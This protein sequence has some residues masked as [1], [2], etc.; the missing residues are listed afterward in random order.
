MLVRCHFPRRP[1]EFQRSVCMED[2]PRPPSVRA[3][4]IV[5][6]QVLR[7]PVAGMTCEACASSVKLALAKV[8]GVASVE[9]SFG[10]RQAALTFDGAPVE[11]ARLVEALAG[12]GYSIPLAEGAGTGSLREAVAFAEQAERAEQ[13]STRRELVVALVFG[14]PAIAAEFSAADPRIALFLTLVVVGWAGA[15]VLVAGARAAAR[16]AP[17]MNTLVALG[18]V[19]AV[20]A[21]AL[22][23]FGPAEFHAAAHHAH[24]A[25]LILIF[26]LLGRW[27][28]TRA[29]RRAGDA[30]QAL[31]NLTPQT[32]R[33]LRRG[34]EVELPAAEARIGALALVR[35]GERIPVDGTVFGGASEVDE[36]ALTGE[37]RARDVAVG[38]R[39]RA[40]TLNG[41]GALQISIERV[42]E[43]TAV[44]RIAH[45][46]QAA[47]GSRVPIQLLVDR[48]SARFVPLVLAA[49]GAAFV[50]G[51]YGD[52][53][54]IRAASRA[55]AV[56]VVACPCA[57]GLATPAAIVAATG[58]AARQ[59][60]LVREA[61]V[62]ERMA[63]VDTLVLDKTGT[64][65]SGRPRLVGVHALAAAR[66]AALGDDEL[67]K[68]AAAVEVSSEQPLGRALVEAADLRGL[69]YARAV[70]FR[71]EPGRGVRGRVGA[72]ELWLGSPHAAGARLATLDRADPAIEPLCEQ[73]AGRGASPVVLLCDDR[74]YAVFELR[75]IPRPEAAA[76][77]RA[78]EA[79]GIAIHVCS[80]DHH[81]AVAFVAAELG[82]SH[83]RAGS[84]P[85]Q[86][87]AYVR[88]LRAAGRR[89]LMVGDGVN[90]A[91]A[92]ASADVGL[93]IG[94]G[95]DVALETADAVLL[96]P[97]LTRLPRLLEL[98]R[99]MRST[100]RANLAWA[101]A[102]NAITLP[103]AAGALTPWTTWSPSPGL[104]AAG[105]AGSSLLVVLNSLRLLRVS[106][107]V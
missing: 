20:V 3:P 60:V 31:V 34:V 56:L 30:L 7:V 12:S 107:R 104:A 69:K 26:V 74:A 105:M 102:Y 86:K 41:S 101:F 80:G 61:A 40:G 100:I 87:S 46:V 77:L 63:L 90:D 94:G 84:T 81:G 5:A 8:P 48:I 17:D 6:Q 73:V 14:I 62:I 44:A 36:S 58:A 82:L 29:R 10:A 54:S 53:D 95:A 13:R 55:I 71:A 1:P 49:A 59:G 78:L 33:V 11:R 76:A 66:A 47:R 89:V 72:R 96:H 70:A 51:W 43:E 9:V 92:L 98:A 106:A 91:P 88:E 79:L 37:S 42:G 52:G 85:E 93:A 38:A 28:E 2:P 99:R 57:L 67:L 22:G 16:A 68:M 97:D 4:A 75:D 32:V 24:A 25:A 15:R 39:V 50:L 83:W 18:S 21:G 45:A 27:L 103:L 65:T 23:A 64:L 35:P 19:A